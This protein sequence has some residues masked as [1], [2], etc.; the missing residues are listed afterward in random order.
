MMF[1]LRGVPV[2]YYGDE[3]GFVGHGVDQD[4]RQDMFASQVASYND[5]TLL[6]TRV[7]HRAWRTSIALH[8]LYRADRRPRHAAPAVRRRCGAAGRWCARSRTE[9]GLF[10]ASRIGN[11][12]R[13]ILVA[14]NTSM[15]R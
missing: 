10:A 1:L 8:P 13:E 11:D 7:D 4:A 14:F 15:R 2:V 6:G 12:G 9:P 3:Q 5:Q